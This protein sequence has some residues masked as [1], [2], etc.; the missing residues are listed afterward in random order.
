MLPLIKFKEVLFLDFFHH[1]LH[2]EI[3]SRANDGVFNREMI[4]LV[5]FLAVGMWIFTAGFWADIV[6]KAGVIL[7]KKRAGKALQHLVIVLIYA[8]I[9]LLKISRRKA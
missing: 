9:F 3:G 6:D 1:F 7:C 4:D 8:E 5:D 2:E